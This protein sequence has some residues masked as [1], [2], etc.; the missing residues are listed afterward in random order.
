[1]CSEASPPTEGKVLWRD[2]SYE[3]FM[4]PDFVL[5]EAKRLLGQKK[6]VITT[7]GELPKAVSSE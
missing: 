1:M 3:P 5:T 7:E 2:I 4:D 6:R